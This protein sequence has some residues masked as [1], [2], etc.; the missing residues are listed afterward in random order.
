M[1]QSLRLEKYPIFALELDRSECRFKSVDAIVEYLKARIEEHP[2]AQLISVFDHYAHTR[3]LPQ[4]KIAKEIL[5]AKT[6]IFCFGITLPDP[7]LLAVR[8][9]SIGVAETVEG[10]VIAFM[11]APM[12]VVNSAMED[13]ARSLAKPAPNSQVELALSS[14]PPG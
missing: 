9:R 3:A 1:K 13:W 6:L 2:T 12:P 14:P 7:R 10:F 11:E 4:G 5:A 8:P